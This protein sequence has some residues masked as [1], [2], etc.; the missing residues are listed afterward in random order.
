MQRSEGGEHPEADLL[1]IANESHSDV[2]EV[3]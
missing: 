3:A 1:K 2:E